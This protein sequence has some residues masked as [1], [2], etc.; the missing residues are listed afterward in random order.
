MIT[1]RKEGEEGTSTVRVK[2]AVRGKFRAA[3][4]GEEQR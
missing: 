1:Q 3:G 4:C 2:S